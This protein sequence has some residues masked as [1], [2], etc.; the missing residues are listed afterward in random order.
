VTHFI[1]K[2]EPL[3]SMA[4][5]EAEGAAAAAAGAGKQATYEVFDDI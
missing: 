5:Q 3:L 1:V 4:E 2:Q